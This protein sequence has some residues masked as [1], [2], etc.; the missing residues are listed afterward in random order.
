MHTSWLSLVPPV[1]VIIAASVTKKLNYSLLFGLF[2]ATLIASDGNPL[3]A[4]LL[5][6]Q[7]IYEQ[8]LSWDTF[9]NYSYLIIIS[10]LIVLI[11]NTG[12]ALAFAQTF[13]KRFRSARTAEMA[14]LGVST[15]LFIDDYLSNLTA[16]YAMRSLTDRFAIPRVKLAYLVHAL[17][18]PLVVICP[19]SSWVAVLTGQLEK[20]NI[21]TV[22][23]PST[24]IIAEP[25]MVYVQLIPFIFYSFLLILSV[26]FVVLM[27]ISF[28]PMHNQEET[29]K[30]TGNLFGGKQSPATSLDLQEKPNSSLIDLILPIALLIGSVFIGFLYAGGF[31]LFGG[32]HSVLQALQ[33]N[34]QTAL[35]LFI[36]GIFTLTV[37]IIMALARKT[38]SRSEIPSLFS[39][40]FIFMYSS[41]IMIF[42]ATTLGEVLKIDL[43]T[44]A[45]LGQLVQ[46]ILAPWLLPCSLFLI[47][48]LISFVMGSTWGTIALMSPIGIQMLIAL[49]SGTAP[50]YPQAIPML[51]PMLGAI[52]AGAICGNHN[53]PISDTTI[54]SCA[55]CGAYP[56]DHI[57]TQLP[58]VIPVI[59][60]SM[61]AFIVAGLFIGNGLLT[62]FLT[63]IVSGLIITLGILFILNFLARRHSKNH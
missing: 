34:T 46:N 54:M 14:S 37:S 40:G 35:V 20:A 52:F 26:W 18:S 12:G 7:R 3:A 25:F 16:G 29:A 38:L 36:A 10:I 51:F 5:L 62:A 13:T 2:L 1:V 43:K 39:S 63:G 42:L 61:V 41:I 17:S 15:T 11:S 6:V 30:E 32:L 24:A 48:A 55:S 33:N 8:M 9:F 56:L 21:S 45:Y 50:F 47:S 31:W 22:I 23:T 27:K 44:G 59:I 57:Y 19:I 53:S 28:G 60:G 49:S 58:Y 4:T